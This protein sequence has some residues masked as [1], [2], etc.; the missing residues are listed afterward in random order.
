MK[1]ISI[2]VALL[3][4]LADSLYA[5]GS[6]QDS[7]KF[8]QT[9]VIK[10]KA[11]IML[12]SGDVKRAVS[13]L[14][15]S[16]EL[17]EENGPYKALN[18][19]I[20]EKLSDIYYNY[21]IKATTLASSG[22]FSMA[23]VSSCGSYMALS[24]GE[25]KI[26][27]YDL[28]KGTLINESGQFTSFIFD[29]RL[30]MDKGIIYFTQD[31][32]VFVY[33]LH[34][35]VVADVISNP[36][37]VS[38][39]DLSLD[40]RYLAVCMKDFLYVQEVST[41]QIVFMKYFNL[42]NDN[43]KDV[44]VSFTHDGKNIIAYTHHEIQM[45]N[46]ES[47]E[48]IKLDLNGK[49]ID[50]IWI[51]SNKK[52]L[53]SFVDKDILGITNL[54]NGKY[55]ILDFVSDVYVAKSDNSGKYIALVSKRKGKKNRV[56]IWDIDSK[57]LLSARYINDVVIF[58]LDFCTGSDQIAAVSEKNI[59]LGQG[60]PQ[61][62]P[63][64]HNNNVLDLK[65]S[66]DNSMIATSAFDSTAKIWDAKTG[67][68]II[69]PILHKNK[70]VS[71]INFSPCSKYLLTRY[72]LGKNDPRDNEN[73]KVSV[74]ECRTGKELPLN[75]THNRDVNS[76]L[77][78][79]CGKYIIT[80]SG[81]CAC[82]WDLASG[83]K[84]MELQHRGLVNYAE[85]SSDGKYIVT[86]SIDR[87]AVIWDASTGKKIRTLPHESNVS[88]ARF[89][90]NNKLLATI[91]AQH[92]VT[93]WDVISGKPV[94][95]HNIHKNHIGGLTFSSNSG[96]LATSSLDSTVVV[97]DIV[98]GNSQFK[99]LKLNSKASEI[100]FINNDSMFAVAVWDGNINIYNTISGEQQPISM[101]H[102]SRANALKVSNDGKFI[103]TGSLDRTARIW[104]IADDTQILADLSKDKY[105]LDLKE[106]MDYNLEGNITEKF[107]KSERTFLQATQFLL[108]K[109]TVKAK[110][111]LVAELA[112]GDK[113]Q[114]SK[115]ATNLLMKIRYEQE[116]RPVNIGIKDLL[117]AKL[118]KCNNYIIASSKDNHVY[119]LDSKTLK[120]VYS[121]QLRG[122][123][124]AL[125]P[126]NFGNTFITIT[127]F[128]EVTVWDTESGNI[129]GNNIVH[130]GVV[131]AQ[132][133]YDGKMLLTCSDSYD[134]KD[135][136]NKS[137]GVVNVSNKYDNEVK[138]WELKTGKQ[139]GKS[140]VF[141]NPFTT[142]YF[143][144]DSKNILT[145]S[146]V[147]I[148]KLWDIKKG[149]GLKNILGES[150]CSLYLGGLS[151][152]G[153]YIVLAYDNMVNVI[154]VA[155][156]KTA[157]GPLVFGSNITLLSFSPDSK[158]FAVTD[159]SKEKKVKFYN[160]ADGSQLY[161]D[162][163]L[164]TS[165]SLKY[166]ISDDGKLLFDFGG[167][168]MIYDIAAGVPVTPQIT[169]DNEPVSILDCSIFKTNDRALIVIPGSAWL[170]P[171]LNY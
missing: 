143:T 118:S 171:I 86:A 94:S 18:R 103:A 33:D 10:E 72:N 43:N 62:Y 168:N 148:P 85:Y 152:C 67:Q 60:V 115:N 56:E 163:N 76:A 165:L 113:Q 74:W 141:K 66:P 30:N 109:D 35:K 117:M 97:W 16:H 91:N 52:H 136:V 53:V 164:Y 99:P 84:K 127:D 75:I 44:F 68:P 158:F 27:I 21:D 111:I 92:K 23:T 132:I 89:S 145:L 105:D 108:Q 46:I 80:T 31:N 48:E 130:P 157:Y 154:D 22:P 139:I 104:K 50:G 78:S 63:M 11:G 26:R 83:L 167:T 5:A 123:I 124:N 151:P 101:R 25:R 34:N 51:S 137:G 73:Y 135:A 49:K 134:F 45:W 122:F 81:I 100:G 150:N 116:T 32:D 87:T 47:G 153:N 20:A 126:G 110:E 14:L 15:H 41:K 17:S 82:I 146:P 59:L 149:P 12:K 13:L 40:K 166:N 95:G 162:L 128:N 1:H 138:V 147:D 161:K 107:I 36:A 90:P 4:L 7:T 125:I 58:N 140:L 38:S 6:S 160:L 119:V 54:Q 57:T 3:F 24:D 2:F 129:V 28:R 106:R 37:R 131:R 121:R 64:T 93:V 142:A 71:E 29:A 65:I 156:G 133:S 170:L 61:I 88:D 114:V 98:K 112:N 69:K 39:I 144:I 8:Y 169:I 42:S 159:S 77:F 120:I 102:S 9:D 19:E 79:P 96:L 70:I 155:T 55:R